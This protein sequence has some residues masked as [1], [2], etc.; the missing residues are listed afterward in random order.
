MAADKPLA[1]GQGRI[2]IVYFSWSGN[3]KSLAQTVQGLVGGDLFEIK[4]KTPYPT[5]YD[6]TVNI[7]KKE[8]SEGARPALETSKVEGL[9]G[10]DVVVLGMPNWWGDM[11]MAVY[12]FLEANDL[13]GKTVMPFVT[14]GSSGMSGIVGTLR[15]ILPGAKVLDGLGVRGGQVSSSRRAIEAWLKTGGLIK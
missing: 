13:S 10:Y 14:H 2:L 9:S 12:A 1:A 7:G 4:T 15:K 6:V 8:Q 3:A 5:D 11:P